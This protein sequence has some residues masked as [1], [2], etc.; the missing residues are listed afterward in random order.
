[1]FLWLLELKFILLSP[2]YFLTFSAS[3]TSQVYICNMLLISKWKPQFFAESLIGESRR[4]TGQY[5]LVATVHG[6]P[7]E[8]IQKKIAAALKR[9]IFDPMLV[10]PKYVWE[11]VTLVLI[12]SEILLETLLAHSKIWVLKLARSKL[13][14]VSAIS[15]LLFWKTINKSILAFWFLFC[16]NNL[17]IFT[18]RL[19]CVDV[20]IYPGYLFHL[21][22]KKLS[23]KHLRIDGLW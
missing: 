13:L 7:F 21:N 9:C 6:A 5:L 10:T 4:Q 2:W 18:G 16:L 8:K 14:L 22:L 23:W 19:T 12:P 11:V 17:V 1:M 3:K 15:Y 20:T